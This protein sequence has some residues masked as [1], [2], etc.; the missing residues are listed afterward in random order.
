MLE[1]LRERK[2]TIETLLLD[3]NRRLNDHNAGTHLLSE[4]DLIEIQNKMEIFRKRI[5]KLSMMPSEKEIEHILERERK[6]KEAYEEKLARRE[7][8]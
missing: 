5:R 4:E 6:K 2:V 3:A 7:E 8:L 1:Q